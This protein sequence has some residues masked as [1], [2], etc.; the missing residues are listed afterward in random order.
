MVSAVSSMCAP[1]DLGQWDYILLQR[2]FPWLRDTFGSCKFDFDLNTK[3][4]LYCVS[5]AQTGQQVL[6]NFLPGTKE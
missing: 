5:L 3:H 2:V 1:S 6:F 4:T